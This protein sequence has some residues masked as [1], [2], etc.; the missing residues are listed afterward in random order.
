MYEVK[1][2][3]YNTLMIFFVLCPSKTVNKQKTITGLYV[4]TIR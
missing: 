2:L 4:E 1:K 3:K